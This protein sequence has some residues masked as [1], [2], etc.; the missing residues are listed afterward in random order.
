MPEPRDAPWWEGLATVDA[1]VRAGWAYRTVRRRI[2]VGTWQEPVRGVVCRTTGELTPRQWRI[3]ALLYAGNGSA[4]S[5]ASAVW[6]WG[7]GTAPD[8]T[9]VTA[10]HGR[11]IAS[12]DEIWVRQSRRPFTPYR[13]DGIS[14]TPPARSVLDAALDLRRLS[15]V[16]ALFGRAVQ[17]Q[18]VDCADLDAELDGAPSAGSRL[19]R[20]ALADLA[21]GSRS[22][23]EARFLRLVRR[24]GLPLPE[25]NGPVETSLGTRYV[26]ALWRGLGKG[27]EIDGRAYHLGPG[28]WQADLLRQNAIQATGIV[29]LRIAA[30]RLWSEPATVIEEVRAFLTAAR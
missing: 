7:L 16:D 20:Q 13:R 23:S 18:L 21:A 22:A 26:D 6:L 3:S 9:I 4:I 2:R 30:R 27:V 25:L 11:S 19:P 29:L 15:D 14:V 12:T 28:Q 1:L 24:S 5:H 17:R 8:R 10:P